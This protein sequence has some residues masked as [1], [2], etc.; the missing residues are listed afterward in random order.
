MSVKKYIN[1][2]RSA[3]QNNNVLKLALIVLAAIILIEGIFIIKALNYEKTIV[4]P[5]V[6]GK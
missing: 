2:Y 6:N 3:V 5:N 1:D 4:V